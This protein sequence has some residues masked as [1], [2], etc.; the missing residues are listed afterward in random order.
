MFFDEVNRATVRVL[1][2][3]GCE[4]VV[5]PGQGCCGALPMHTG[6]EQHAVAMA[7][8]TIETF[9]KANV[10]MIAI[11]AAWCGSTIKQYGHLLRADPV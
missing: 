4:V 5:P 2:A 10:D 3:E 7:R 9:E 8:Q 1:A 6:I 11:N